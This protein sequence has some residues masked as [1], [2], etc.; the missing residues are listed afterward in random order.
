MKPRNQFQR[1]RKQTKIIGKSKTVQSAKDTVDV[2]KIIYNY[3][4]SG[5]VSH[6][7]NLQAQ[8]GDFSDIGD[9]QNCLDTVIK[10]QD[11]FMK[12]P[13]SLR[14]EFANDP[15]QLVEFVS[16]PANKEKAIEL[17][18]IEKPDL[19]PEKD[20]VIKNEVGTESHT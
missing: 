1:T 12:L 19:L 9:Y 17:G 8:Y 4:K 2:N 20:E 5:I 16:N 6:V 11:A 3:T 15:A 7:N 13:S 18:L 10:A 14:K